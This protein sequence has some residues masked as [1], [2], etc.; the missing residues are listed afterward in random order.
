MNILRR[1]TILFGIPGEKPHLHIVMC[2]PYTDGDDMPEKVVWVSISSCRPDRRYDET[3]LLY[4]GD[5]PFIKHDSYVYYELVNSITVRS[6]QNH[7]RSR[8]ALPKEQMREEVFQRI[9]KGFDSSSVPKIIRTRL[10]IPT[11]KR[12]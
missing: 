3:C 1:A 10:G 9:H 4:P 8:W 6:V 7:I 11:D 2:D 12:R 5:H